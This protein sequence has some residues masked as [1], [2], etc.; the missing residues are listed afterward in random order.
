ME[1]IKNQIKN[2]IFKINQ[3]IKYIKDNQDLPGE[4]YKEVKNT[5]YMCIEDEEVRR[6]T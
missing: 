2:L 5:L 1:N 4:Y 3:N 6:L